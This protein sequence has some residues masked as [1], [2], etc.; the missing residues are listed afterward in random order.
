MIRPAECHALIPC[1]DEA[2]R[3]GGV[4]A[5]VRPWVG[6]VLVIDDGSV[7]ATG[8]A[9]RVAG[10]TVLR[11]DEPRGKG[12]SLRSG[13]AELSRRGAGWALCLDGDGQHAAADIPRFLETAD[14]TGADL[15]IGNRFAA[16]GGMP[17]IRRQTNRLMSA[18]LGSLAGR[19]L[20]DSQCGFRLVSV[21]RL[22]ELGLRTNRFEIESEMVLAAARA[23]WGIEFV[24]VSTIYRQER[25]K[26][27]PL[28][29]AWR[30]LVWLRAAA[31]SSRSPG[32]APVTRMLARR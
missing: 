19:P 12:A 2:G 28:A 10:A 21:T 1:L 11:H 9:A 22:P 32:C 5:A 31:R 23:G 8:E 3:I 18:A 29:D 30:W 13:F 26:I 14:R 6:E 25:S 17:W 24:P 4:V 7:D 15:V 20:P 27:R 16:G